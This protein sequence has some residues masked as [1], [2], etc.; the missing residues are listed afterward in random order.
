[1]VADAKRLDGEALDRWAGRLRS[2]SETDAFADVAAASPAG[3][4]AMERKKK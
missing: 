4:E 1:M 3:R 2:R